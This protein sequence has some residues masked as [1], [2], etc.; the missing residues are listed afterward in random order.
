MHAKVASPVTS[1]PKLQ[2]TEHPRDL[3]FP[4]TRPNNSQ[5]H[6]QLRLYFYSRPSTIMASPV[7]MHTPIKSPARRVLG[8]LT[9]KAINT[10]P[11]HRDAVERAGDV[12]HHSPL[13]QVH[14][15]SQHSHADAENIPPTTMLQASRKRSIHEV[16]DAENLEKAQKRQ[17]ERDVGLRD[18]V[19]MHITASG[20]DEHTVYPSCYTWTRH[21]PAFADYP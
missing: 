13:K 3:D 21:S 9:P 7:T 12:I 19:C 17:V 8:S 5:H 2:L 20:L 11:K 14:T 4:Q 1:K 6:R 16:D 15:I 18:P 10:P